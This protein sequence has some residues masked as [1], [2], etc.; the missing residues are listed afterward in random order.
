M[1][2][3]EGAEWKTMRNLFN[4]GFSIGHLTTLTSLVVEETFVFLDILK[5]KAQTG[6][7][8]ELEELATKLAIDIIARITLYGGHGPLER[9]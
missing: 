8:F 2:T 1:L 7:L 5:R 4:S 9:V 6:E 3:T